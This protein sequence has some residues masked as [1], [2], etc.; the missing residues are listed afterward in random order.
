MLVYNLTLLCISALSVSTL[1]T[2]EEPAL[3]A[4]LVASGFDRPLYVTAPP[5][6][7]ERLFVVEQVEARIWIVRGGQV[8]PEPFLDIDSRVHNGGG[9]R[10]LLGLAFHPDYAENGYFYVNYTANGLAADTV[11]ARYRVSADDPDRADPDSEAVIRRIDQPYTNHNGGMMAFGPR[12]GYLYVGMGDGGSSNDPQNRAQNLDTLLGKML[13]L[14]VDSAFPYAIPPDNPFVDHADARDEIWAYGLRNPWRFSFDRET[15]DLYIGD[16]GQSSRE[17]IN[18]QPAASTGGE[19][20]GWKVAEGFACRGGDGSC[21]TQP[22]FTPPIHDYGRDFG[23]SVTGGYVY[24]GAA[25]PELRGTY[26]FADFISGRIWSLRY[27]GDN[28]TEFVERTVE[29]DP[30]GEAT[31][32]NVSSFGEDGRGELY[33]VDYDGEIY[34]IASA[35]LHGDVNGDGREDAADVQLVIN[36]VLGLDYGDASPDLDGNGVLDARDVQRAVNA[37]LGIPM[38]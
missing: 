16:V 30:P 26:F 34:R 33:I 20:Y 22:G 27:D 17:E 15:G 11:I 31:I 32:D 2:P 9:E 28:A 10:G 37:V 36:A 23:G 35:V 4:R 7:T 6:D 12:D 5:G 29:L 25:L 38:T 24:R 19:N 13:R 1:A 21:G 8:L 3:T 18:F 14:D